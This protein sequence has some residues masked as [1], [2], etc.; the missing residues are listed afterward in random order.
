MLPTMNIFSKFLSGSAVALSVVASASILSSCSM[1]SPFGDASEGSLTIVT[2]INGDVKRTRALDSDELST[3][4]EKCVVYIENNK[5]IIRRYRGVDNIPENISLQ[6]GA[7]VAEAWSGDSVSASFDKKFY[8]AYQKFNVEK[9][10]NA[11]TLKCNIANV[12]VSVDPASLEADVNDLKVTFTHSKGVLV[13]NEENITTAKGYFM[14]PDGETS[15]TYIIEGKQ[16]D[17]TPFIKQGTLNNVKRAHEYSLSVAHTDKP[18]TDGGALIQISIADIPLIE[19]FVEIFPAP[20]AV[21]D[22]FDINGQLISLENNFSDA[23]LYIRA[24][25]GFSSVV[26]N[27]S[28]N[29]TDIASGQ[30][31][32]DSSVVSALAEKGILVERRQSV[33][34]ADNETQVRRGAAENSDVVVDELF[35]TFSKSF[36]DALQES[37]TEYK[38]SFVVKDGNDRQSELALRV[39]NTPAAVEYID[40]VSTASAPD[41]VATPMAVLA[42]SATLNG[43]ILDAENATNY[44]IA[45]RAFGSSDWIKAYPSASEANAVR[46]AVRQNVDGKASLISYSVNITGLTPGTLYEY[47]AFCDNFDDADVVTF[48]TESIF[49]IPGASFEEWS[50]YRASTMLGTKTIVLPSNTGDKLTSY[51]GSGNEGAATANMTLTDK[52][53]DMV[54][55]GT[56]S[57]RLASNAALGII[58]AGNI[59]IGHYVETEKTSNG[60]LM[61]GREYNGSH[62]TKLRFYVNYRPGGDVVVKDENKDLIDVVAG[63]IDH[64][65]VY[66]AL[67]DEP[68]EIHTYSGN[69]KLFVEEDPHVLAYGQVTWTENFG[70]DG[71]LQMFEIPLRYKE[72]AKTTRATHLVVTAAASKFG[73]YYSGSKSSVMYLDDFELIYE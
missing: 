24:Y 57:A 34:V 30:N 20:S 4:R 62:P 40:P 35:V 66:V 18:V 44:G 19:E 54:H 6:T 58:A 39:A 55:S 73:D 21:G 2:E 16:T 9:G 61:L 48:S 11:L 31:L 12:V 38:F 50:T 71:Q 25:N 33:D 69:R 43:Y 17:G 13:F 26:M 59:F 49:V 5:G 3:L 67:C 14:M 36:L 65:Q 72:S 51:W 60:V 29:Y 1:D 70:P 8:R 7:Y 53:T 47:K 64:G 32:L 63:G 27:F 23:N 22:G 37:E 46:R 68:I 15:L 52:S 56:Y 10:S 28:D 41:P 42:R 45:Y